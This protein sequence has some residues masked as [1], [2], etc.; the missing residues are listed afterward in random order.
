MPQTPE[1]DDKFETT[2]TSPSFPRPSPQRRV[3]NVKTTETNSEKQYKLPD[4]GVRK[5]IFQLV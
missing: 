2:R 4:R 5:A 1:Y 3:K